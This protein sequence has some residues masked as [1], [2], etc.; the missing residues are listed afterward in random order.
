MCLFFFFYFILLYNTVL[1]L[2]YI[3]MNPPWVYMSS[4]TWTPLP[5]HIISLDHPRAPAPS[6]LYPALN[7]DWRFISYMIVYIF[8]CHSPKSSY[9]FPH[10]T[11]YN[12]EADTV[13]CVELVTAMVQICSCLFEAVLQATSFHLNVGS[14]IWL[15]LAKIT[16][17]K[18]CKPKC[19]NDFHT[20]SFPLTALRT[21][22]A[23]CIVNMPRLA[24]W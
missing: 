18:L 5:P 22:L 2:P 24:C 9:L 17:A 14:T 21:M 1:V 16:V 11:L 20:G 3:D 10:Q 19:E 13:P 7:I 8:Q 23:V 15:N 6:I 12:L 4:Q